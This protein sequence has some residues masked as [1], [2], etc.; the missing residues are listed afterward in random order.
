MPP[1]MP[2]YSGETARLRRLVREM[3]ALIFFSRHALER[4]MEHQVSKLEVERILSRCPV[5]RVEPGLRGVTWNVQGTDSR[6]RLLEV[7]IVVNEHAVEIKVVT[8]ID[9][10]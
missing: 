10:E 4:M 7:V 3:K 9:K 2:S 1:Q 8:V 6:E 5:V